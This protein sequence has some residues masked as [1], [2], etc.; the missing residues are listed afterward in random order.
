MRAAASLP[1]TTCRALWS[2]R[3]TAD[4]S[5]SLLVVVITSTV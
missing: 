3:G 5:V 4:C 1:S 2:G